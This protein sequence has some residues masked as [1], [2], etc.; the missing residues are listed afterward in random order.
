MEI[1]K[2]NATLGTVSYSAADIHRCN[3]NAWRC[4]LLDVLSLSRF[5]SQQQQQQQQQ[6]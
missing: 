2:Q 4:L 6:Q 5:A 3:R 1:A